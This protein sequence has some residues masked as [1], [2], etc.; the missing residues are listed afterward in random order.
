MERSLP[1]MPGPS[2]TSITTPHTLTYRQPFYLRT[3]TAQ[4]YMPGFNP[5]PIAIPGQGSKSQTLS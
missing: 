3:P 5:H 1:H 4:G 2:A